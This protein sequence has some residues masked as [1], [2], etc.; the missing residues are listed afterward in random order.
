ME[1]KSNIHTWTTPIKLRGLSITYQS[2]DVKYC[3][4]QV[5]SPIGYKKEHEASKMTW[6]SAM[7]RRQVMNT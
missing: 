6:P 7:S 1:T 5:S 2:C 4:S 3:M